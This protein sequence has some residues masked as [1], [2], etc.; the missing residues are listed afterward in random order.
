M[1]LAQVSMSSGRMSSRAPLSR[2]IRC[3]SD[4]RAREGTL[5]TVCERDVFET[6]LEVGEV[7]RV[8]VGVGVGI[9]VGILDLEAI[10]NELK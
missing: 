4:L 10:G 1:S 8:G 2:G 5:R 6:A 9:L 7:G 3:W